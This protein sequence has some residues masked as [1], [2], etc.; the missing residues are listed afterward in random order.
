MPISFLL[1]PQVKCTTFFITAAGLLQPVQHGHGI[2]A[3]DA[4]IVFVKVSAGRILGPDAGSVLHKKIAETDKILGSGSQLSEKQIVF[5]AASVFIEKAF[6]LK[7][8]S[9]D[10]ACL[11]SRF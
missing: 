8:L 3:D 4:L 6:A 10:A 11:G 5:P 7:G 9:S 2:L 1:Y